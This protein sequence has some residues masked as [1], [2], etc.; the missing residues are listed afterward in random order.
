MGKSAKDDTDSSDIFKT[1]FGSSEQGGL[2]L[3]SDNPFR[4]KSNSGFVEFDNQNQPNNGDKRKLSQISEDDIADVEK[5][6]KKKD[7]GDKPKFDQIGAQVFDEESTQVKE[8]ENN[9]SEE[10]DGT[11]LKKKKKREKRLDESTQVKEL[12]NNVSEENDRTT[13]K[14]KKKREKIDEV[15]ETMMK[16]KKREKADEVVETKKK[17]KKPVVI[18][19]EYKKRHFGELHKTTGKKEDEEGGVK[20]G[21]KSIALKDKS[22]QSSILEGSNEDGSKVDEKRKAMKG[23]KSTDPAVSK[24]SF[25]DNDKLQR[26]VFVGNLPLKL[27][28]KALLKEFSQFGEVESVRIR[29]VP[30]VDSKL[31][32]KSAILKGK[33]NDAVDSVHAYIVFKD[34]QSA[35]AALSHNMAKVGDNHIRVDKAC[36]PRGKLEGQN[37]SVY[38]NRRTVFVGNL[39]FDVKDEELYELFSGIKQLESS[40]EAVRVVR[41]PHLSVGKGIAYVMFKTFD[42]AKM[43][44]K[45]KNYMLRNRS[46]RVYHARPESNLKKQENNPRQI[47]NNSDMRRSKVSGDE[48]PDGEKKKDKKEKAASLSYQGLRASQSDRPPRKTPISLPESIKLKTPNSKK[49]AAKEPKLRQ[50][51]RPAVAARKAKQLHELGKR[52]AERNN[53]PLKY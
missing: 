8:L 9:V 21:K 25:D 28:K 48:P 6:K 33:I 14:K 27:K 4:R 10:N 34:E 36:P 5:K 53:K 12:E 1:L 26:T 16:E 17:S 11:T 42:A 44:I 24:E 29:S 46:L 7:K 22:S 18:E 43:A 23:D 47:H 38:D 40:L 39:P 37:P 19:E 51:K 41:D 15:I 32:R 20:A 52:K 35:K 50:F 13:T 3:F 30:L 31:P 2:S 45:R 49:M